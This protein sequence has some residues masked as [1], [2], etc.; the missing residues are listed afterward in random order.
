M[1]VLDVLDH[2][3]CSLE[4]LCADLAF[5]FLPCFNLLA[6]VAAKLLNV[7]SDEFLRRVCPCPCFC[8]KPLESGRDVFLEELKRARPFLLGAD[9]ILRDRLHTLRDDLIQLCLKLKVLCELVILWILPLVSFLSF[10]CH[11]LSL[12]F[13]L[14]LLGDFAQYLSELFLW[15]RLMASDVLRPTAGG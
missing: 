10:H 4:V 5:V 13:S 8:G 14:R 7:L 3:V 9:L 6:F 2:E 1:L 15:Y 12:F 11:I